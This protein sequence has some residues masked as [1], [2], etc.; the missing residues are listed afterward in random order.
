MRV[1]IGSPNRRWVVIYQS[2]DEKNIN[3]PEKEIPVILYRKISHVSN[4]SSV[5]F[6]VANEIGSNCLLIISDD[7]Q[8]LQLLIGDG[9][10]EHI[11]IS[12]DKNDISSEITRD[13]SKASKVLLNTLN[14]RAIFGNNEPSII[15]NVNSKSNF[16]VFNRFIGKA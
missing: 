5:Y 1:S 3:V 11:I 15:E 9:Y 14:I 8:L 12:C 7:A 2:N 6:D 10:F 16:F 13:E 4:R